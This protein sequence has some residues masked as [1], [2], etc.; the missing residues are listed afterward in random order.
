MM[1]EVLPT[2]DRMLDCSVLVNRYE[3]RHIDQWNGRPNT[4]HAAT[5][6]EF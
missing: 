1:L 3:A 2:P 5:A 6:N 4:S